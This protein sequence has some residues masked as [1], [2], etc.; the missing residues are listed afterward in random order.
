MGIIHRYFLL[1]IFV[2]FG[3]LPIDFRV[4]GRYNTYR[5]ERHNKGKE[6]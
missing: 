3:N 1:F 2:N 5:H 4:N 6:K